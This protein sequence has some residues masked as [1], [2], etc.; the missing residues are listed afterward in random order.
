MR[1][2]ILFCNK[3]FDVDVVADASIGMVIANDES[4]SDDDNDCGGGFMFSSKYYSR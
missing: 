3:A 2:P 1:A 4:I